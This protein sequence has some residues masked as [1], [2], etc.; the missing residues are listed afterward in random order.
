[1]N[2]RVYP[3]KR[4][5]YFDV[6]DTLVMHVPPGVEPAAA[7]IRVR[8]GDDTVIVVPHDKHIHYLKKHKYRGSVVVVWSQN[9]SEWAE[10][11]VR[12]LGIEAYVDLVVTKPDTY[13]D[14]LPASQFMQNRVYLEFDQPL[15]VAPK[16][17]AIGDR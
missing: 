14:D 6:D 1:M 16:T 5:V 10:N 7:A 15:S 13:F 8:D 3:D 12:A 4:T 2:M 17:S 11:V 9:G